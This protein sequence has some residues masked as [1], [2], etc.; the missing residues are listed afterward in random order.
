VRG[1]AALIVAASSV[2][3]SG[4]GF[5]A[6]SLLRTTEESRSTHPLLESDAQVL[7]AGA[8]CDGI[9]TVLHQ[10]VGWRAPLFFGSLV[11][12]SVGGALVGRDGAP[13][14]IGGYTLLTVGALELLAQLAERFPRPVLDGPATVL[15]RDRRVDLVPS[16]LGWQD[17]RDGSAI[18]LAEILE[19]RDRPAP[20]QANPSREH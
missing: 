5:T 19:H 9:P 6:A 2:A 17:L 15:W 11:D 18:S 1:V 8:P 14:K 12:L 16:D 4:C 13:A 10:S 3:A 20:R 7:C